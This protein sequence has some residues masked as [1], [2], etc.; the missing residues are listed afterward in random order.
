M[1]REINVQIKGYNQLCEVVRTVTRAESD[2][3]KAGTV[4]RQASFRSQPHH[5]LPGQEEQAPS[6]VQCLT[7]ICPVGIISEHSVDCSQDEALD[8]F[9]AVP[10]QNCWTGL[11]LLIVTC[12]RQSY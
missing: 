9:G 2:N 11:A 4:A 3:Y 8:E 10:T 5:S 7:L 1:E 6:I 12:R